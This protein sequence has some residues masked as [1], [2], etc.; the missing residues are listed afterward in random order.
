MSIYEKCVSNCLL[1]LTFGG[2]GPRSRWPK[3]GSGVDWDL[4]KAE[5]SSPASSV[6]LYHCVKKATPLLCDGRGLCNLFGNTCLGIFKSAAGST[7]VLLE[8]QS[9]PIRHKPSHF[10]GRQGEENSGTAKRD[11][12]STFICIPFPFNEFFRR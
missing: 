5:T 4:C 11:Q 2:P 7:F 8:P 9:P 6:M 1:S 12:M 3:R 10:G